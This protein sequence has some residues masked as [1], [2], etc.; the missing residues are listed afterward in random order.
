MNTP[1]PPLDDDNP[2]SRWS[3]RKR[4]AEQGEALPD[5]PEPEEKQASAA[6]ADGDAETA[7]GKE[8]EAVPFEERI[9]PRTGK[10]MKDLTDADMPSLD[11]LTPDS[12]LS[13]FRGGQVSPELLRAARRIVYHSAKY[14][15]IDTATDSIGDFTNFAPLGDRATHFSK[16]H[17]ARKAKD[18]A[19]GAVDRFSGSE[20]RHAMDASRSE[21]DP[22]GHGSAEQPP[23]DE[24]SVREAHARR[25]AND[26][27]AP[28][29]RDPDH[30][31]ADPD[32]DRSDDPTSGKTG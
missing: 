13:I 28:G 30:G 22:E 1:K 7:K 16:W 12:D 23:G 11:E 8:P 4:A 25:G 15:K 18:A 2:F 32:P 9:D 6:G 27:G 5:D 20:D 19:K 10:K 21:A 17:V 24:E 14:N 3:R 31:A 26:R 29:R